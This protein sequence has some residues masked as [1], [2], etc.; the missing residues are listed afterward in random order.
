ME[1]K[2]AIVIQHNWRFCSKCA[3]LFFNGGGATG[4]CPAGGE[5]DPSQ[6]GDYALMG[7]SEVGGVIDLKV[8]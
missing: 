6:S 3:G 5:H 8:V 1:V 2:V 4:V 7:E